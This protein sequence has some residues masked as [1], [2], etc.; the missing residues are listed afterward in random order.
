MRPFEGYD[1]RKY[2]TASV[3]DGYAE[4]SKTYDATMIDRMDRPMLER[5][6]VAWRGPVVDL[7]CGTGR[8]G[9]W[10]RAKGAE[11]VDG[12]D[13]TDAMLE[14]ARAKGVYRRLAVGDVT[15]TGLEEGAYA[16]LLQVLADEHLADLAPLYREARRLLR[17]GGTFVL[18]GYHPFFMLRGIPTHFDR[19]SG[20]PLAIRQYVHLTSDHIRAGIASGF[21]LVAMDET[22][23]DG[24]WVDDRP[25]WKKHEG[26]PVS[27]ALAWSARA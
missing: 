25:S 26:F 5:L 20:E 7:A 9:P 24:S 1:A 16:T 21:T 3:V 12:V 6:P 17:S 19:A 27:F 13:L 11:P 22:I 15:R 14:R 18:V 2:E 10:L 4:W 23:V 8:H